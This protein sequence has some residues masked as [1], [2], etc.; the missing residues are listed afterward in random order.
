MKLVIVNS[1]IFEYALRNPK[2]IG[3]AER[4]QWLL[5]QALAKTG[6]SVTV[7]I[8]VGLKTGER[9]NING[10]NFVGMG[11]GQFLWACYRLLVSERPDWWYWR[12]ADHL[13]GPAVQV[14]KF[15]GVRTIFASA[16]D[17]D[18]EPR[19]ATF[20]RKRWWPLFAWGLATTDL[21]F[22]QHRG[23][24][25]QLAT[26]WQSK[27]QIVPSLSGELVAGPSHFERKGFV[28]WVGTLRK[29][30]R[31]DLLIQIARQLP[32]IQFIVCGGKST[33][34]VT[35]EYGEQIVAAL[36]EL[37]NVKYL[38]QVMPSE[39]QKIIAEANLLLSTADG[40]GFP[41]TFLEAWSC[42][43]PIVT[44]TIDPDEVI[45]R[46]ALGEVTG[47]VSQAILA[48]KKLMESP[49]LRDEIAVRAKQHVQDA[50]SESTVLK[51][52]ELAIKN[53]PE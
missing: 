5:A 33:F 22:V 19:R 52:I 41:N 46:K 32:Q 25:T 12:A 23:Q 38:G 3:G 14:A 49:S 28:A 26:R 20:R 10:V 21:I 29:P 42:G 15:A 13:W 4:Q 36:T 24:L 39:T 2:N 31:A 37:P 44:L 47:G 18:V 16:F 1:P 50:H 48:I 51:I 9:T 27:A 35:A 17:T 6:W 34:Q 53:I 7:G 45:Q 11:N 43:T 40:E 8:R 30:K